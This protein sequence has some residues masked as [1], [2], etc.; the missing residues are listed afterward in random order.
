LITSA[1]SPWERVRVR[2]TWQAFRY[3]PHSSPLPEGEGE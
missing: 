1:L 2:G 3:Y